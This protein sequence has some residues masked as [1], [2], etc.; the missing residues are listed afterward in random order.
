MLSKR[1]TLLGI[2]LDHLVA[3]NLDVTNTGDGVVI[4]SQGV[5][6]SAGT[7]LTLQII[8]GGLRA[9]NE[10]TVEVWISHYIGFQSDSCKEYSAGNALVDKSSSHE[11]YSCAW[12]YYQV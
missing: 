8:R 3:R 1:A 10:E 5:L 4:E 6:E 11:H 9:A 12:D 7:P 2:N